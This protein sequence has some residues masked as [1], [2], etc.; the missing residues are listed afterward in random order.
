MRR[1]RCPQESKGC[2]RQIVE[3]IPLA[4]RIDIATMRPLFSSVSGT[5][6][7]DPRALWSV[8]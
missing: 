1:S 4:T 3:A 2:F 7:I 5:S 6:A 8:A